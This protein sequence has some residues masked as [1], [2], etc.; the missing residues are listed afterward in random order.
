MKLSPTIAYI[1][2]I[3]TAIAL[4]NPNPASRDVFKVD[5]QTAD[6]STVLMRAPAGL[7]V[8]IQMS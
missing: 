3:A 4:P 8:P 5:D 7:E 6:T 2:L 1:S